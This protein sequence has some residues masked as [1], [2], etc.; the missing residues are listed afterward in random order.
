MNIA[1]DYDGTYTADPILWDT[2]ARIAIS[3]GHTLTIV[4][5]RS[6]AQPPELIGALPVVHTSIGTTS[7]AKLPYMPPGT[8][9]IDDSPC[10]ILFDDESLPVFRK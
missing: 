10:G 6:D 5:R 7:K 4:T 1:L 2:F 9:W 8:I 3:R